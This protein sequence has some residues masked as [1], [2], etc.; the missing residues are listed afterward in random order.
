MD[1]ISSTG[2]GFRADYSFHR[3]VE[4]IGKI[5]ARKEHGT[6]LLKSGLESLLS[7]P[8]MMRVCEEAETQSQCG[9]AGR[10]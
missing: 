5:F 7:M 4:I 8:S 2:K 1:R 3:G 10:Q 9:L 6:S